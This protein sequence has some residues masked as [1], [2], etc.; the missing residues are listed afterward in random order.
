MIRALIHTL[1]GSLALNSSRPSR[2][3]REPSPIPSPSPS[4]DFKIPRDFYLEHGAIFAPSGHGKSQFLQL[5]FMVLLDDDPPAMSIIDSQGDML[6]KMEWLE[7]FNPDDGIS[8]D[9]LVIIDPED[10][11]PPALN[12]F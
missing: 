1:L 7:C 6:K 9:R 5:L 8:R 11:R 4:G 2:Q 3:F 10:A 12:L